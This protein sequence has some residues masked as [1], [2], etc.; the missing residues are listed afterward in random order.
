MDGLREELIVED[1][2]IEEA[3]R[4]LLLEG[5]ELIKRLLGAT[6]AL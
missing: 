4:E 3:L 1:R 2:H 5:G 6:R